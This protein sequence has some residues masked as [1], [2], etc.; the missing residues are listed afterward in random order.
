MKTCS[1]EKTPPCGPGGRLE[2]R[3]CPEGLIGEKREEHLDP[4]Q[5]WGENKT[6][7]DSHRELSLKLENA[8]G[9]RLNTTLA[10]QIAN[11]VVLYSPMQ[12]AC[13]LLQN[14][15]NHPAFQFFRD[16]DA[17]WVSNPYAY[18]IITRAVT[19]EDTITLNL[20]PGGGAA[21][22]FLK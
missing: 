7:R 3:L 4:A 16:F 17:D 13:D 18:Q 2:R 22:T 1:D 12:M 6:V 10:K 21:V 20:A 14:Y 19:S 5:P 15:E 11:W 8:S 9:V